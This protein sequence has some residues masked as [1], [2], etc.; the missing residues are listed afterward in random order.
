MPDNTRILQKGV[1]AFIDMIVGSADADI[2]DIDQNLAFR[3]RGWGLPLF[4]RHLAGLKAD[5]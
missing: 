1:F 4:Q 5:Y 2:P 3:D